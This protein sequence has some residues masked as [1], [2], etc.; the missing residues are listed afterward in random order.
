MVLVDKCNRYYNEH[1]LNNNKKTRKQ[2]A[3]KFNSKKSTI[4]KYNNDIKFGR[5]WSFNF[6][7]YSD[8]SISYL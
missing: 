2:A 8:R 5:E 3:L 1:K 4:D 6:D 7:M